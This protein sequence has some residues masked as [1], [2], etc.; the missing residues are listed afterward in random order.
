[1][2]LLI[3]TLTAAALLAAADTKQLFNGKDL[4]GWR[5]VGPGR[6]LVEDG[7]LKTEGGMGLLYYTGQKF[8]NQTIHVVFKTASPRANSGVYIR[9]PEAPDDPW[10]GVHN[11]YE[12]QI[13]SSGDDWHCT[14]AL[15]SLSKVTKRAQKPSGEWNAMDIRIEG[16]KTTVVLNGE[17]VNEFL[18][19]QAVPERKEWFEPV[20]G[21][22][23]DFGYIGLQNHDQASTVYFKEVSVTPAAPA[24]ALSQGDRDHAMSYLHATRKQLVD[25]LA[26]ISQEQW[27]YKPA[28][29]RWSVAEVTEHLALAEDNL[30]QYAMGGLAKP[31]AAPEIKVDDKRILARMTDRSNKA[32]APES[33]VPTGRWKTKDEVLQHFLQSR[34]R[35]IRYLRTTPESLR[36]SFLQAPFGTIDVY[37]ALL[38]IPS[39]NERHLAQIKEVQASPGYPKH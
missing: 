6:F 38:M 9:M 13:D 5:M 8:G 26:G 24:G 3:L 18:N 32:T 4:T 22:R 1:M 19:D 15:Y 31:L 16:K 27:Q 23:A 34:D 36:G 37:Q 11:G 30:F 21:P 35:N 28:P 14:G 17:K 39:H 2:R 10:Y 7:M 25:A 29:D 12:V 33:F 20:R